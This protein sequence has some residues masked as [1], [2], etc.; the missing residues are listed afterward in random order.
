MGKHT[1]ITLYSTWDLYA[2]LL[3]DIGARALKTAI[4]TASAAGLLGYAIGGNYDGLRT[5]A[6][7]GLSAAI[8]LVWN[9]LLAWSNR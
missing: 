7:A 9:S 4:Q 3:L 5:A 6:L 1:E 8:S 2:D